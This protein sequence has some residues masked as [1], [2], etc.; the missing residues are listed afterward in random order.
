MEICGSLGSNFCR[1][2]HDVGGFFQGNSNKFIGH[3]NKERDPELFLRWLQFATFSPIVTPHC[4]HC[5]LRAWLYPNFELLRQYF[6]LRNSLMP[7]L[8]SAAW[9]ASR[10]AVLPLHALYIDFPNEPQAYLFTNW[11]SNVSTK[12]P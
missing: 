7:Y 4:N 2:R 5:E 12:A 3:A 8:Y 6:Q 1:C 10:T 9:E 11:D